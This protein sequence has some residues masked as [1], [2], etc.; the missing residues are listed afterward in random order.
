MLV[1]STVFYCT[2]FY[3]AQWLYIPFCPIPC[4][5]IWFS[6]ILPILLICYSI[7][8]IY[9]YILCHSTLGYSIGFFSQLFELYLIACNSNGVWGSISVHSVWFDG[10]IFP[11]NM[12]SSILFYANLFIL[13][14]A[15][16]FHFILQW[17]NEAI[18]YYFI[19]RHVLYSKLSPI[20]S[21]EWYFI[22][23]AIL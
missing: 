23:F 8:I 6:D 19:L 13:F 4:T 7:S 2:V 11:S 18:W 22:N 21:I 10:I 9:H 1:Y 5:S 16:L 14:Y 20:N 17:M 15:I 3:L 12:F